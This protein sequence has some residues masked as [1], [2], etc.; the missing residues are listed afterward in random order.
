VAFDTQGPVA[1][2][3]AAVENTSE[4]FDLIIVDTSWPHVHESALF[5]EMRQIEEAINPD[6]VI[7]VLD[8]T[9]GQMAS[10]QAKA[11]VTQ[12]DSSAKGSVERRSGDTFSNCVLPRG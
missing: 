11:F 9:I 2:A 6:E 4:K 12:V 5:D 1:V 10:V 7:F 8:G 3:H